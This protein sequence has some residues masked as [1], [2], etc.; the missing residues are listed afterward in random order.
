MTW[1]LQK[2]QGGGMEPGGSLEEMSIAGDG[3]V[4]N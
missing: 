2:H 1:A 4:G 3:V